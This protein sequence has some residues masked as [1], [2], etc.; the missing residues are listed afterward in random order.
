[1][2]GIEGHGDGDH[3]RLVDQPGQCDLRRR[4]V[5][6]LGDGLQGLF[7]SNTPVVDRRIGRE[8]DVV[9]LAVI[10]HTV[11][12]VGPIGKAVVDLIRNERRFG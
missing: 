5:M 3:A 1:M 6:R 2:L 9:L 12:G 10:Q 8:Q 7:R 11:T 4:G